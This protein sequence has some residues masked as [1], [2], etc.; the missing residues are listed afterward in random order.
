MRVAEVVVAEGLTKR[1]DGLVAVDDVSFS[2]R[3]GEIFG[4]LGPNGAGKTTTVRMLIGI[5]PPDSG[6]AFVLGFDVAE[7]PLKVRKRIGVVPEAANVYLDLTV[8]ENLMFMAE[9]YGV[10]KGVRESRAR[11]LLD[12]MGLLERRNVKAGKL[13]KGLR[14]RLLICMALVHEPP[15]LF[16][17]EPT[18]GLDVQSARQIRRMLRELNKDEGV[19]IFLTTHNMWEAEELCHRIAIINRGRL[20]A[21]STPRDL[22]SAF[23]RLRVVEV[24]FEGD[25]DEAELSEVLGCRVEVFGGKC[26]ARAEDV[27]EAICNIVDYARTRGLRIASLNVVQPSLEEIF[28]E[29]VGGG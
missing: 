3:E 19:T 12:L 6:R 17:D 23:A 10:P 1:F 15:L 8:W 26:R 11:S 14:Q 22:K 4:F 24:E 18:S 20:A 5:L 29:M 21:V 13:S 28:L 16:L 7:E 2:V 27:S 9:L 25:F